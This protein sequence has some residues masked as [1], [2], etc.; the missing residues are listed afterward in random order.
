MIELVGAADWPRHPRVRA[1][2]TDRLGGASRPPFDSFNLG[3]RCGDDPSAVA[4]NRRF[5]R[6]SLHL[7]SDP[8]WLRQVHGTR[9]VQ[10]PLSPPEI[11]PEADAA[12]TAAPGDVCVIQTADCLP[13]LVADDAGTVV[14][15]AHAGWRGLAGGVLEAL[16]A[17]LPVEPSTLSAWMGPAIGP[18]AFEVGPEVHAAFADADPASVR[19]FVPG[20]PGK[21]FADLFALARLRLASA[22]VVRVH[23]GGR[24]TVSDPARWYSF[25]RDA[26]CGRM[27]TLVWLAD[28]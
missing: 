19:A 21:Y 17:A 23:G 15:G 28:H 18:S 25:R 14:G 1:A 24:C 7:S 2:T 5:L 16:V 6:E 22:G 13:V 3:E 10:L 27:A 8:A 9:V 4:R 12:W 11:A 26:R 20:A